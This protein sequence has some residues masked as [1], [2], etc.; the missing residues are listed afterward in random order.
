MTTA[1][2]QSVPCPLCG[3]SVGRPCKTV[4][5]ART[6]RHTEPHL[7]RIR[8]AE[9]AAARDSYGARPYAGLSEEGVK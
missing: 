3:A 7:K 6:V 9:T 1:Q 8:A 2:A 5:V 4:Q